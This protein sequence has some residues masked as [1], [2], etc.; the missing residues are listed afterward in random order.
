VYGLHPA[1]V[2][3][4]LLVWGVT[5]VADSAQFSTALTE[6]ADREYVGTAVTAQTAIGFLIT[7]VSIRLVPAL[8]GQVGW[9]WAFTMLA[10]GP[11]VGI[12][13]MAAF[14]RQPMAT[15]PGAAGHVRRPW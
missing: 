6:V 12:A 14:A 8:A 2:L 3:G 15:S 7:V 11:V 13:A 1:I 5:V 4:L 9:R 10:A